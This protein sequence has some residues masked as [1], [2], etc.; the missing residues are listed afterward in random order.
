M[1]QQEED[2]PNAS[3]AGD[4]E[5]MTPQQ[6]SQ[7]LKISLTTL[8]RRTVKGE[9]PFLR[10]GATIRYS[11]ALIIAAGAKNAR[12]SMAVEQPLRGHISDGGGQE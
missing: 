9:I 5:I 2:V 1:R 8:W 11:K 7:Y 6:A 3:G 12:A 10:Y 4:D